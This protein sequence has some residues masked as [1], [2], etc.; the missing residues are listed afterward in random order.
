MFISINLYL[1]NLFK[2]FN[3]L[4]M[5]SKLNK[6]FYL[7]I[8]L[9]IFSYEDDISFF[10][11]SQYPPNFWKWQYYLGISLQFLKILLF[12]NISLYCNFKF[13]NEVCILEKICLFIYFF[14]FSFISF[15]LPRITTLLCIQ[16]GSSTWSKIFSIS[17][18][19]QVSD[20]L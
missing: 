8:Y 19:C 4:I 9:I 17:P 13:E 6:Y 20:F 14:T 10:F 15:I 18:V 5:S 16:S 12:R 11:F 1:N 3:Y 2:L 7:F